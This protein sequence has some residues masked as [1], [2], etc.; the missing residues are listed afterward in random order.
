MFSI[1]LAKFQSKMPISLFE[2]VITN[3]LGVTNEELLIIGDKGVSPQ[4]M[5]A[6]ALTHAYSVAA[7]NLGITHSTV[8]QTTKSRGEPA[9][10]IMLKQ[11]KKLPSQ[12]AI[13]INVSNRMGQMAFLGSSFRNYCKEKGHRFISTASLGMV[14]NSK[15]QGILRPLQADTRLLER[16][17]EKVKKT[18]DNGSELQVFTPAGTDIVLGIADH[19][20]IVASGRYTQPG[21]GGNAI[22]A[23]T[24]IAP[25]TKSVTGTFVIDGS[26][27]TT[28][29]THLVQRPVICK[30]HKGEIVS[31]NATTESRLL[32]ESLAQAHRMAKSTMGIRKIGELGI[33]LNPEASIIGSTIVDEKAAGT[34][35]LAIGSNAWFGGDVRA[36]IHL[37]QV[38]KEPLFKVDGRLLRPF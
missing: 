5:L 20:A 10:L 37:D 13:V 14:D 31:W 4:N 8:Y 11:L 3:N 30:I 24:Y 12:S 18:L 26:M 9:D 1:N 29:R 2:H 6:P 33:G 38:F 22:P 23:E 35:H 19:K 21:T 17:A 25:D 32:Q 27:R 36:P 7:N 28:K 16:K 34:A 15:L